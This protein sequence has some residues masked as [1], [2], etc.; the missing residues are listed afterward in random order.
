MTILQEQFF[1]RLH[2]LQEFYKYGRNFPSKNN[3]TFLLS[4]EAV[5]LHIY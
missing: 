4:E 1:E 2:A 3:T 5:Y